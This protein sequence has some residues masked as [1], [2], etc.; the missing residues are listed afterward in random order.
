MVVIGAIAGIIGHNLEPEGLNA[1]SRTMLQRGKYGTEHLQVK[2]GILL[3]SVRVPDECRCIRKSF[4]G[5]TYALIFSGNLYNKADLQ[6]KLKC[7]SSDTGELI[8]NAYLRWGKNFLIGL[9]GVFTIAVFEENKNRL[10]LARDPM[11]ICPLF[12]RKEGDCFLF[13]SE[14]K[15]ML[16]VPGAEAAIDKQGALEL[17]M[18]GPGRMPGSGVFRGIK[19]LEPGC[20][21]YFDA[22]NLEIFRYWQLKD[23]IHEDSIQETADKI[24]FLVKD[25]V[26]KQTADCREIGTFLSG[27]LDSSILSA[28]C[29][30]RYREKPLKT[31]S[32]DYLHN[33]INFKPGKFQPD[34]DDAYVEI[35]AEFLA[36]RHSKTV[37]TAEDLISQLEEATIARDLPGMG[38]VDF[39]LLAFCKEVQK[40]VPTVLSGEC[41]DEIFGGYP[42]FFDRN[43]E[44]I[45][46]FPWAC[47]TAFRRKLMEHPPADAENFVQ[48]ACRDTCRHAD[49]LPDCS[50]EDRKAKEMTVLNMR[51]FMQTLVERNDRMSTWAGLQVRVPFCDLRIAEYLY[52]IPWSMKICQ[53]REKGLLRH[54]V[55]DLL[56]ESV[57]MRKKSPYPKTFD[58]IYET[59][60]LRK[61][62]D[63][64]L[65]DAPI[66]YL[67]SRKTV[68]ESLDRGTVGPFYGQLMRR[69]QFAAWILQLDFWLKHYNIQFYY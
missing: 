56:P 19:E 68:A 8:L 52:R 42:W 37:L 7:F 17:I 45:L 60:I 6:Q 33:D 64:L 69:P 43:Q 16:A 4:G 30:E 35:M 54:A 28:I 40:Q 23:G 44:E 63:L 57:R 61:T 66:W 12:Y 18:L 22:G 51:W 10:F 67:I 53:G 36:C 24:I 1:V 34:S 25:A 59:L 14:Q 32:V 65:E 9:N 21:C 41:A 38:D 55:R 11:G 15:T 50:S 29:G 3:H 31:F 26:L 49:I 58:P 27:G 5:E 13:A 47:N 46:E 20:C 2:N 62:A 39:S 48:D